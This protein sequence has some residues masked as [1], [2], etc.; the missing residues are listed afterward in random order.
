MSSQPA[1]AA[2]R[3]GS[4]RAFTLIEVLMVV[5]IMGIAA[6]VVIPNAINTSDLQA[7]SAARMVA[8]DLQYAQDTAITTQTPVTVTF[9]PTA[10]SIPI[11]QRKWRP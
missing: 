2:I 11:E 5:L 4:A 7:V 1:P 3:A 10:E 9:Q 8:T 6:A